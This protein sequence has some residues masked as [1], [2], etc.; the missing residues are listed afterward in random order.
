MKFFAKRD[1][2]KQKPTNNNFPTIVADLV[3]RNRNNIGGRKIQ[4]SGIDEQR[5]TGDTKQERINQALLDSLDI[6]RLSR[7]EYDESVKELKKVPFK[8]LQQKLRELKKRN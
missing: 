4:K 8:H 5:D 2:E 3:Q 6:D 7:L 1:K